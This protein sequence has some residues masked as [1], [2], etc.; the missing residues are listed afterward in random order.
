MTILLLVF[1]VWNKWLEDSCLESNMDLGFINLEI[2]KKC[3]T[4]I[5]ALLETI[6]NMK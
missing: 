1:S 5:R 3:I 6:K 2:I 4:N